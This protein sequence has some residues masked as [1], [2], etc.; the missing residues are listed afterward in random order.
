MSTL[1]KLVL[2][3][4]GLVLVFAGGVDFGVTTVAGVALIA[5]VWELKI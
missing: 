1:L 2:T 3:G 5:A 4:V